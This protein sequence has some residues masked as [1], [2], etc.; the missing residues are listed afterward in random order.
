MASITGFTANPETVAA[1]GQSVLSIAVT[2]DPGGQDTVLHVNGTVEETG[3]VA[4]I[5]VTF[6]GKPAEK[7]A[8]V[9]PGEQSQQG[10]TN[11][12]L[13]TP[14]GGVLSRVNNQIIFRQS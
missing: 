6:Q 4:Q 3:Q 7:I 1:G 12:R 10:Y 9:L 5:A 13:S 11:I 8:V 14:D 2:G